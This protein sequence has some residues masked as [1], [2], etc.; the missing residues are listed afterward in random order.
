MIAAATHSP[1]ANELLLVP[2]APPTLTEAP[3]A[4]TEVQPIRICA[5]PG[6]WVLTA[7]L[8]TTGCVTL[9]MIRAK[10]TIDLLDPITGLV[11][12][13]AGTATGLRYAFRN[14]QSKF[15]QVTRDA[16]E[17]VGLFVTISL[18]GA[19]AS[20]AV[21]AT[22]TGWVDA[23][24][25]RIDALLGLDWIRWYEIVSAH[26]FLQILSRVAYSSIFLTPAIIIGYFAWTGRT[27]A[28]RQFLASFW[29]AAVMT[30]ILFW[31]MPAKGALAFLWHGPIP[32]MP[33]SA[34]YQ[35]DIIPIL[36]QYDMHQ[37]DL[38]V[39]RGLV[40]VPSF[41]A[42]SA[43]LYMIAGWNMGALRWPIIAVN[44]AMLL[45]IPVEGTH[46]FTDVVGGALVALLA[47]F[48]IM[49]GVARWGR[50]GRQTLIT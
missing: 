7:M 10:L 20:Y 8:L 2:T 1:T 22:T 6:V 31:F 32:Y 35:A 49:K 12:I 47:H 42:A 17:F 16:A 50:S 28:A 18:L 29:F 19:V 36:R 11:G 48:I 30:L 46:Y 41:H 23:S 3:P 40:S 34:L 24:L 25:H 5:I 33:I 37:V 13:V 15:Q 44:A 38:G 26:V 14:P 21:A 27:T 39:I 9:A 4:V 45:S 43:V